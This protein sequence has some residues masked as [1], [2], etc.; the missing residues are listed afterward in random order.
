[1]YLGQ[2][3]QDMGRVTWIGGG[4]APSKLEEGSH[5]LEP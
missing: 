4:V 5:Q 3:T 1:M 2:D